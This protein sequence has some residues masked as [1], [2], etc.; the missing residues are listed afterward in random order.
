MVVIEDGTGKGFKAKVTSENHLR[1]FSI[2]VSI[3]HYIN[4]FHGQAYNVMFDQSPT[5]GDDCI[6]YMENESDT[7]DL[8]A[9]GIELQVDGAVEIYIQ[10]NARGTRNGAN[11]IEPANL[12]TRSGKE[13]D[14]IFEQGTDLDGGGAT[15]T[16]G[17]EAFRWVFNAANESTNHNF[18]CDVIL[19]RG[20]TFTV[21]CSDNARTVHGL[22]PVFFTDPGTLH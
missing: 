14:G 16:G 9:E 21:W 18:E 17:V 1:V 7:F 4:H 20:N 6:L 19:G 22:I 2:N 13:A 8:V 5:A 3:E 15:L 12:N 11:E 10:L